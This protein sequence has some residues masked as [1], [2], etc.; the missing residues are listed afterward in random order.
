MYR[1]T[2]E[3]TVQWFNMLWILPYTSIIQVKKKRWCSPD[4]QRK[5]SETELHS[6]GHTVIEPFR[7]LEF[8]F[9]YPNAYYF[10]FNFKDGAICIFKN[11][12][13]KGDQPFI[14]RVPLTLK[15]IWNR[16]HIDC[17][18]FHKCVPRERWLMQLWSVGW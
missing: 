7:F 13:F 4:I 17:P 9:V 15:M 2:I 8:L 6:Q 5:C 14:Q 11:F 10:N 16:K 18:K 1:V 3:I 12:I